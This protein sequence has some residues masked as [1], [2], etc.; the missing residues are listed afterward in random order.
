MVISK[1]DLDKKRKKSA[2]ID[3]AEL[4]FFTKGYD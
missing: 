1:R 3:A 2:I 4:L